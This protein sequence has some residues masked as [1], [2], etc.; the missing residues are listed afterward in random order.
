M[1][2]STKLS[3]EISIMVKIESRLQ[4]NIRQMVKPGG[5]TLT[6]LEKEV[7]YG[8][9]PYIFGNESYSGKKIPWTVMSV[10]VRFLSGLQK[11]KTMRREGKLRKKAPTEYEPT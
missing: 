10:Q 4:T 8:S 11:K 6:F 9:N 1:G 2:L 5:E 3:R 7:L